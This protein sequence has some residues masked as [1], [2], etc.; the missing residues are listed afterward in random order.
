MRSIVTIQSLFLLL[1]SS[2]VFA[3]WGQ[4]TW[5][6]MVWGF[7]FQNVPA[8]GF[9]G[10]LILMSSLIGAGVLAIKKI[11]FLKLL[12]ILLIILIIPFTVFANNDT[13]LCFED[14]LNAW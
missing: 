8:I 3:L 9:F 7:S 4:D 12:P 1:F 14:R 11:N 6:N 5:G 13:Y 2:N 10:Q